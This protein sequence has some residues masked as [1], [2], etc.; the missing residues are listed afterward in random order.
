M[1]DAGELV[2][3]RLREAARKCLLHLR[4]DVHSERLGCGKC[5]VA[6]GLP[7]DAYQH[8]GRLQETDATA[9]A[10]NQVAGHSRPAS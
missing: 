10:V 6:F 5:I 1:T 2:S 9:L 4:Q 3:A 7:V 8:H